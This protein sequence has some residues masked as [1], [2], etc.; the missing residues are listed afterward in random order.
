MRTKIKDVFTGSE[1]E[2]EQQI[3]V[4]K[5]S[6]LQKQNEITEN[7]IVLKNAQNDLGQITKRHDENDRKYHSLIQDRQREQDLYDE[8]GEYISKLCTDLKINI[9][10][11]IK[12]D[13]IRAAGLVVSIQTALDDERSRIQ[14]IS[15][16]NNK[17]DAE[18]EQEI[19]GYR[20]QYVQ[21]KSEI[22]A[23]AKQL[24]DLEQA[25]SKQTELLRKVEQSGKKLME[26][27]NKAAQ[28]KK[29]Y[30]DLNASANTQGTR[31]EIAKHKEEKQKLAD[32]LEDIDDQITV[33][34]SMA[35]ILAEVMTKEKHIEKRES[36]VRRIK[37]KHFDNLQHLFPDEMID[38]NY[39][40]TIE[41]LGKKLQLEVNKLEG[42]VRLYD[43]RT[44]NFKTQLQSKKQEQI[45][46]ENELRKLEGDIDRVCEQMPF[47]QV[48]A[49]AKEN[50][51]K[52]QMDHSSYK[53]SDVFYKK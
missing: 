3:N 22:V 50:V 1:F 15:N 25:Q 20:E 9:D 26:I 48:L 13:N 47:V 17:V 30:N 49:T 6:Q 18:Q 41:N 45:T 14:E 2:L 40:R 28:I 37:N 27:R 46:L 33:I 53:S 44:Q 8:K 16:T 12:N 38:A 34:S 7:E 29:L 36:E 32:E 43:N 35:N 39:K 51:A 21:I 4:F 10:F 31:E 11:D 5:T 23:L 52:Y 24:K 42:Q 19:R